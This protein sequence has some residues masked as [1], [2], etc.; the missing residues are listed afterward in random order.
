MTLTSWARRGL[1]WCGSILLVPTALATPWPAPEELT[2]VVDEAFADYAQGPGPG[3]AVGIQHAGETALTRAYG[4]ADVAASTPI[5]ADTLFNIASISKQFTVLSI[6]ELQS[7][8]ELAVGD[9]IRKYL[10]ELPPSDP[11]TRISHLI[12]HS[13]G[14]MDYLDYFVLAGMRD[15]GGLSRE[16]ALQVMFAE[17]ERIAPAGA[18][19]E[20]NNGGY[21]LLAE[22]VAR[23]SGQSFETFAREQLLQPLG[24]EGSYF[25]APDEPDF[26]PVA[27]GYQQTPGGLEQR[28]ATVSYSGDGGLVTSVRDFL[29]FTRAMHLSLDPWHAANAAF[30]TT[31]G[32]LTGPAVYPAT[33]SL[34]T[35]YGGGL[36]LHQMYGRLAYTH[37]GGIAGYNSDFAYFPDT[38]LA[39]V[40][41]CNL[42][43]AGLEGR[44]AH[45]AELYF[46][47]AAQSSAAETAQA[48]ASAITP[49][50]ADLMQA[51]QGQYHSERLRTSYT[52]EPLAGGGM[53]LT[54]RSP[55]IDAPLRE[56]FPGAGLTPAGEIAPGFPEL[57]LKVTGREAGRITRFDLV[58][59]MTPAFEFLRVEDRAP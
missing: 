47:E 39:I 7:R 31:P 9:D 45:I 27:T 15:Y 34:D 21:L 46:G 6:L 48:P 57:V 11:I 10:P 19:W 41:F 33:G 42:R 58:H 14:L 59:P 49:L 23:V 35:D 22:I 32:R 20:Y 1:L 54:T 5:T 26:G 29:R 18:E 25:R 12:H 17:P 56:E 53:V 16:E 36:G 4:L 43:R 37:S 55:F 28:A 38:G 30:V 8:G 13:S 40:A 24:M 44:F 3:C 52:I 2:R 50:P 51:L